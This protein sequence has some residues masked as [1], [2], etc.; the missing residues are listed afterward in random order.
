M[1]VAPNSNCAIKALSYADLTAREESLRYNRKLNK[2]NLDCAI[3][4]NNWLK[5]ELR[6]EK[7]AQA[8]RER[9]GED[10]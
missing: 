9:D 5:Q 2:L 3:K 10:M 7:Y 4:R 1:R 6:L 8:H